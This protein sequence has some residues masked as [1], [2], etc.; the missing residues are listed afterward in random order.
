MLVA[1]EAQVDRAA[2]L[3]IRFHGLQNRRNHLLG[4]ELRAW[5]QALSGLPVVERRRHVGEH[6]AA[7]ALTRDCRGLCAHCKMITELG[8]DL[9]IELAHVVLHVL[10]LPVLIHCIVL[11]H[12]PQ[13]R[14][15]FPAAAPRPRRLFEV[16]SS[17]TSPWSGLCAEACAQRWK[18]RE[19]RWHIQ[20]R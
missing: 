11:A 14:E 6:L 13:R 1:H 9:S 8:V 18:G 20:G 12:R 7:A 5:Q 2:K 16:A 17:Q 10:F 15:P 19:R 4:R 3:A